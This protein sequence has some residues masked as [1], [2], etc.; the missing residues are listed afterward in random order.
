M[1]LITDTPETRS[2]V[3]A[4][5]QRNYFRCY[6][7]E[8][9]A[10]GLAI[11]TL[12]SLG[13]RVIGIPNLFEEY[14]PW[15]AQ[16]IRT[17][18]NQVSK[19]GLDMKIV[20]LNE[21]HVQAR[22]SDGGTLVQELIR[23]CRC[24]DKTLSQALANA[25]NSH[26]T[27]LQRSGL[28]ALAIMSAANR[29]ET[30]TGILTPNDQIADGIYRWVRYKNFR[31]PHE[32]S[33]L[34]FDNNFK[35]AHVPISTVDFGMN[36]LGYAAAQLFLQQAPVQVSHDRAIRSRCHIVHRGSLGVPVRR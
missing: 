6:H 2:L 18:E 8:E 4:G 26:G 14:R 17:I 12:S 5:L 7:D 28:A 36:H 33:I 24:W 3:P 27:L 21:P 11:E 23:K 25:Y 16:R 13:H 1:Q 15:V 34:S 31:I 32:L 19:L 20:E 9:A 30:I 29:K 10:A 22:L 35:Y